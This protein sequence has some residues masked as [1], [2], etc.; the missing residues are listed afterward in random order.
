MKINV[1]IN[2]LA[3][4]PVDEKF[5]EKVAVSVIKEETGGLSDGRDIEVSIVLVGLEKMR[6][7]NKEYRKKD[8][9]T[10]VLSFA[11]GDCFEGKPGDYPRI[12]GEL[13]ICPEVVSND[14]IE[15]GIKNEDELAW[16]VV[17][18]ILHLFGYD[19]E[20]EESEASVMRKKEESYLSKFK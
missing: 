9:A 7:V 5:V 19:H 18:G 20:K 13:M 12:L 2:N 11:E 4:A 15:S 8:Y 16:V 10:D 3:D 1:G 14:A 6:K 17:H